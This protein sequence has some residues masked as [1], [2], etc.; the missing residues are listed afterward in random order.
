MQSHGLHDI[1]GTPRYVDTWIPGHPAA[2]DR[3]SGMQ[4]HELR[5]IRGTSEHLGT[6]TSSGAGQTEW[7]AMAW[8]VAQQPVNSD[9]PK[10]VAQG[11]QVLRFPNAMLQNMTTCT[12]TPQ[13]A[14]A[15]HRPKVPTCLGVRVLCS[16]QTMAN[17]PIPTPTR[18]MKPI[19]RTKEVPTCCQR[20]S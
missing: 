15:S 6:Q 20:A 10:F 5:D 13:Q 11:I 7:P 19:T 9:P 4:R 8:G 14:K 18:P 17:T 12:S 3:G 2:Q 16:R 1:R